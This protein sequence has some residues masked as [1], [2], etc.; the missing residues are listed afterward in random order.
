MRW[1]KWTGIAAAVLLIIACFMTWVTISLPPYHGE[2]RSE[3]VVSGVDASGTNFG[4]PAYFH[5][6]TTFFFLLF[7]LRQRVWAKRA[8]LLVTAVNM[9]WAVRNY[10]IITMCR[11]GDCP[12]KHVAIYLIIIA[13]T[14]MLISALFPDFKQAREAPLP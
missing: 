8:N 3:V 5:F 13:S 1:I 12:E 11:G 10:F 7:T 14:L 9:A 2:V 4:K 6:V